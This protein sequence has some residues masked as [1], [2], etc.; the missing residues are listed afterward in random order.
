MSQQADLARGAVQPRSPGRLA[1]AVLCLL[2]VLAA[3]AFLFAA[4][5]KFTGDPV[6]VATFDAMGAGAWL[7]HLVAVLEVLGA[8]A[9][10]IPRLAALAGIAFVMLMVGAALTH[11]VLGESAVG[12]LP[13]LLVPAVIAWGRWGGLVELVRSLR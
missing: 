11:L 13:F 4:F 12:T 5:A 7:M 1:N 2:Q 3:A 9:L 6:V 10:L 8:I